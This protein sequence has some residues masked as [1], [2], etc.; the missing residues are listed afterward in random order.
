MPK[1][2]PRLRALDIRLPGPYQDVPHVGLQ[3]SPIFPDI[4]PNLKSL[5][6][7]GI[8][9]RNSISRHCPIS[10]LQLHQCTYNNASLRGASHSFSSITQLILSEVSS[11]HGQWEA[12]AIEFPSLKALYMRYMADYDR[13]LAIIVVPELDTL[14]LESVTDDEM[15]RIV[16]ESSSPG[17]NI[18]PS[19]S[20]YAAFVCGKNAV[21]YSMARCHGG[22]SASPAFHPPGSFGCQHLIFPA[23]FHK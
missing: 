17:S 16:A 6:L 1:S 20:P 7:V 12:E 23:V 5:H 9:L 18:P 14:Y 21:T 3:Y 22:F 10:S 2:A 15:T 4:M 13:V 11:P 8:S 19:A